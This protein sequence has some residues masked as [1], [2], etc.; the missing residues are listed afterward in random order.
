MTRQLTTVRAYGI[1]LHD[2]RVVLVRA[3]NPAI[4][5]PLWWLPGGGIDFAESPVEA[6]EREFVEETGLVVSD[7]QLCDVLSDVRRRPNGDKIHTVRV[8]Y[9]VSLRGGRL[10]DEVEG[11]TDRAQWFA[12]NELDRVNLAQYTRHALSVVLSK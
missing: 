7:P 9:R 8:I 11:T 2:D 3:S 10:R 5:P 1:L 12:V 4:D 6:L